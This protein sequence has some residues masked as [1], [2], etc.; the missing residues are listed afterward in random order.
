MAKILHFSIFRNRYT[1]L[2]IFAVNTSIILA[3][4]TCSISI[5]DSN[6]KALQKLPIKVETCNKKFLLK[7]DCS[8]TIYFYTDSC[9]Q[10]RVK[11]A[12]KLYADVDTTLESSIDKHTIYLQQATQQLNQVNIVAYKRIAK[13]DAE[14]S[15]YSID[16]SNLLKT[17][18]ANRALQFLP[19]VEAFGNEYK[20][21]GRDGSARIK[22][23]GMPASELDLKSLDASEIKSIEVKEYDKDDNE[24]FSGEINIIK[25]RHRDAKLYG[26]IQTWGGGGWPIGGAF[27][28]IKYHDLHWDISLTGNFVAN[29]Q[30][31]ITTTDRTSL[32]DNVHSL[33]SHTRWADA[34]QR[35]EGLRVSYFASDK[36]N[37]SFRFAHDNYP[38]NVTSHI[39]EFDRKQNYRKSKEWIRNYDAYMTWTYKFTK[40][41]RLIGKGMAYKYKNALLYP[42]N[43]SLTSKSDMLSLSGEIISENDAVKFLGGGNVKVGYKSTYRRNKSNSLQKSS[44]NIQQF[45]ISES[46]P[47]TKRFSAFVVLS[48]STDNRYKEQKFD[49][50]PTVRLNYNFKNA[51]VLALNYQRRVIRPSINY[52]NTDTIFSD[53]RNI[54]VGNT[55]LKKQRIDNIGL[56]FRKQIKKAYLTLS[57]NYEY[58]DGIIDKINSESDYDVATYE[59]VGRYNRLSLSANYTQQILKR[60]QMSLSLSGNYRNFAI[61]PQYA[62]NTISMPT[63]GFGY[64]TFINFNYMSSKQWMYNL[65]GTY[66]PRNLKFSS[67]RHSHPNIGVQINKNFCNDRLELGLSFT[68][69]FVYFLSS[70]TDYQFKNIIQRSAQKTYLYN[71]S[72]SIGWNFGKNFRLRKATSD[73]SNDDLI[74]EKGH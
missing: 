2:V 66:S 17:T 54:T 71:F 26:A 42:E 4:S 40:K 24:L 60:L 25:K 9:K 44:Y 11:I 38:I 56:T 23:D 74:L 43:P 47:I 16:T 14:K 33:Y 53:E 55:E 73:I 8:G 39:I 70:Y 72:I 1:A 61:A 13:T 65:Y 48:G 46:L 58:S 62:A 18:K 30:K 51:G 45:Y 31:S 29:K 68:N 49:F 50:L 6:E 5:K 28:N 10:I 34:Q 7:T 19:G 15:I 27:T 12:S 67:I 41:N 37:I 36:F 3:Q 52:L 35:S 20:L 57:L 32:S 59:N 63:C 21:I 64:T 22:I 69:T